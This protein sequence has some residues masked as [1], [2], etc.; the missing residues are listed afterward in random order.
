MIREYKTIQEISGPLM[1]V[2]HVQGVTYD[3]LGEIE[4]SDG[5][6]RRCQVLEVN[7]DSAVVQLFESSAGIN[8]AES[9]IRFLGH[10]L[11]LGVS[12]DMLGR[13]FNGMG[14]P[15]DGGPAILADEYRD[16][17]GLPMNPA[18]R[19]YP[20][21]FIQ[22]GIST[23]D[24]LNTLVRGQ[25]LPI[26]SGSGLPHA[27]L[28]AQIARQAKVLDELYMTARFTRNPEQ[29][30]MV[31]G[32]MAKLRVLSNE[33]CMDLVKDI[34]KNYHLPYP[35]TMGERIALARQQSGAEKLKGH[36]I[37]ALE[38]FDPQVRHM[39]V[40]DVLSF[41][42]PVGDKG[43]KMRLFLTD[44]GYRKAMENQER[45]FIKIQNHAKV[46]NGYLNYDHKDRVL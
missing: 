27:A 31:R 42:S 6:I 45:G 9:K 18:G 10:P 20:N 35:R 1:V 15:I 11:Q 7:G 39:V 28:A 16:I 36:D 40:F 19:D 12:E 2:D 22:T 29:R 38:R 24:G 37:M 41:E 34:Q 14:R 32:L 43:D 44:E 17:N 26:F 13:V 46:H 8:L 21:E 23:I 4:L 25:K 3:E 30:D 33:Q 5:T